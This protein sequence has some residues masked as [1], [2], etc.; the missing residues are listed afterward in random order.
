MRSL[1]R[2]SFGSSSF[3]STASRLT[4]LVRPLET[5]RMVHMPLG[6]WVQREGNARVLRQQQPGSRK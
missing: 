5:H 2:K 1:K 4:C 6:L 3:S